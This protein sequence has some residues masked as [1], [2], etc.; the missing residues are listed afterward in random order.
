M[1]FKA[2]GG[3]LT[4]FS[5]CW[6]IFAAL[7]IFLFFYEDSLRAKILAPMGLV[8]G[9]CAIGLWLEQKWSA[10]LMIFLLVL[11]IGLGL[12]AMT[13][14]GMTTPHVIKVLT[15]GYNIYLL[16]DWLRLKKDKVETNTT[17]LE[18]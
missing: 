8:V 2:P 17:F 1:R 6:M 11:S 16:V 10:Q 7:G 4:F 5:I 12:F 15:M 9:I 14:K 18:S 13:K 3:E